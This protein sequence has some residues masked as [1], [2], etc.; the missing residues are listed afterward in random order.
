VI[1]AADFQELLRNLY[2]A[3]LITDFDGRIVDANPRAVK[4]LGYRKR[5]LYTRKIT[6]FLSGAGDALL[7]TIRETLQNDRFV[8][9]QAHCTRKDGSL[10]PSE[11]STN[12]L[13]VSAQDY[14][15]FFIRDVSERARGEQER[16]RI[17]GELERHAEELREKNAL[18]AE[19]LKMAREIQQAMLPDRYP[20]FPPTA[21]DEDS[22]LRFCHLY[23]PC[24]TLGGDFFSVLPVCP[25]AAGIFVGDV[26]GHGIRAALVTAIIHGLLDELKP[27]GGDPGEFLTQINHGLGTILRQPDE[28]VFASAIYV[29]ADWK[30][31]TLTCASAGHPSPVQVRPHERE[32][33]FLKDVRDV[34]G[35]ALGISDDHV[36]STCSCSLRKDDMILV[37]TDGLYEVEA[38]DAEE[39]GQQR[40]LDA[41]RLRAR[42]EP[43]RLLAELVA[44]AE[45]FAA[46]NGF[47]DDV[48]LLALVIA[49]LGE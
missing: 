46:G 33:D 28:F 7:P 21:R 34:R 4:F 44:D 41:V 13:H 18:M 35:P 25:T 6:D 29:V 38:P 11:V 3:A 26:M 22:A 12:R 47:S 17:M 39:Y 9:I 31:G 27:V 2:D 5:E 30:T 19:D 32:A 42:M 10:F 20:V 23:R 15:C 40:L 1:G 43:S 37:F 16:A 36:Y 14:L 8:L 49:R 48:C 45:S 24:S